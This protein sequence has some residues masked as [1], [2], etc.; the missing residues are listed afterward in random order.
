MTPGKEVYTYLNAIAKIWKYILGADL[1][2]DQLDETT[3]LA[4]EMYFPAYSS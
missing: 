4:L 1:R 2:P 3:V